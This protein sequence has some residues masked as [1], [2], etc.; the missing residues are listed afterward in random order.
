MNKYIHRAM[1]MWE[2]AK[3]AAGFKPE[4][5]QEWQRLLQAQEE[6]GYLMYREAGLPDSRARE[7]AR[8]THGGPGGMALLQIAFGEVKND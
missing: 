5:P 1:A 3:P 8:Q 6:I 7:L 2:L 4:T